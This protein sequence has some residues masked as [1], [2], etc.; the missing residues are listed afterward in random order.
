MYT[1]ITDSVLST[2]HRTCGEDYHPT[3]LSRYIRQNFSYEH[4]PEVG[5]ASQLHRMH[6]LG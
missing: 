4:S 3:T 6:I 1:Y 2:N 5:D